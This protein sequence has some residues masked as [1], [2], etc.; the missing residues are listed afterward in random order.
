MTTAK[1]G[2]AAF[3]M[4]SNDERRVE[5]STAIEKILCSINQEKKRLDLMERGIVT[6]GN[7]QRLRKTI[8]QRRRSIEQQLEVLSVIA[9]VYWRKTDGRQRW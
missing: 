6:L 2:S 4:A 7:S 1:L 8:V 9:S 5:L 3:E